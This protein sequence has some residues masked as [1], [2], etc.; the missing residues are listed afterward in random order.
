VKQNDP[1]LQA[2]G[3]LVRDEDPIEDPRMDALS[4]DELSAAQREEL[5]GEREDPMADAVFEAFRPIDDDAKERFVDAIVAQ[6]KGQEPQRAPSDNVV[7]IAGKRPW[8]AGVGVLGTLAAAAAL[9]LMLSSGPS[10][11]P[12]YELVVLGGESGVRSHPTE[13]TPKLVKGSR[14]ELRLR[15]ATK[16]QGSVVV[17]GALKKGHDVRA[18]TP[19]I[20]TSPDGAARIDGTKESL[21]P[22]VPSG[23]W[24]V[25]IG[26]GRPDTL[27]AEPEKL[28]ELEA[29]E[30]PAGARLRR[31]N[32]ILSDE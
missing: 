19:P 3:E 22:G 13:G 1:L 7:P 17:R 28:I 4:A 18:W 14:L 32:V 24:T 2:L 5:R 29:G 27:P 15:P 16:T 20:Q 9:V 26:I 31:V 30:D 25:V 23:T 8:L 10:P 12:A 11:L 6:T 21:F